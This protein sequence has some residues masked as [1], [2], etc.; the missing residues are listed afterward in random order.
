[1]VPMT[2]IAL[3]V[4]VGREIIVVVVT[5]EIIAVELGDQETAGW[6]LGL[7]PCVIQALRQ[8]HV[9]GG[10]Q[11]PDAPLHMKLGI[12]VWKAWRQTPPRV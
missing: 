10:I 8:T 2:A 11:N 4:T 5:E 6:R 3:P 9:R 7:G 12:C 1:M